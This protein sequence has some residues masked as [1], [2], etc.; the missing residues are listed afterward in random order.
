MHYSFLKP[1]P[2]AA[3]KAHLAGTWLL[4]RPDREA[5]ADGS[6]GR[7]PLL[8]LAAQSAMLDTG[9]RSQY[10]VEEALGD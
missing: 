6:V 8:R 2:N 3:A 7:V 1:S 5:G 4:S 9:W 10:T